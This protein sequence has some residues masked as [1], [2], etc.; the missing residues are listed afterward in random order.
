MTVTKMLTP[1]A[2]LK[3]AKSCG[4]DIDLDPYII[5]SSSGNTI[6]TEDDRRPA[7]LAGEA[8]IAA[9]KALS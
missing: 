2:M 7:V 5:K 1:A 3:H 8:M 4:L 9:L 6:A